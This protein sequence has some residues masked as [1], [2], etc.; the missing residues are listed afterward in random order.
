[1]ADG[2]DADPSPEAAAPGP[3][4]LDKL[5]HEPARLA[6]L[7]ALALVDS[8]DATF[9]LNQTGLTWGNLSA[10]LRKLEDAGYV[11]VEKTFV[12][13]KPKTVLRLSGPGRAALLAYREQMRSLLDD[14]P[15]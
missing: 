10:H 5:V 9:V 1:M 14:L 15:D 4:Q 12:D 2:D 11:E 8:A 7:T 3:R 6:V 13:R